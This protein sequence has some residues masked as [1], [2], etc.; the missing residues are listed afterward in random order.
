MG[1]SLMAQFLKGVP[2]IEGSPMSDALN[3]YM[4][5][6]NIEKEESNM[7]VDNKVVDGALTADSLIDNAD[8]RKKLIGR[9]D[10]L[11]KVK[12][13]FLI[14][15]TELVTMRQV[16]E[17]Y[18]VDPQ[19]IQRC[20]IRNKKELE[21][22][23]VSIIKKSDFL[24]VHH[25]HE[26]RSLGK[27]GIVIDLGNGMSTLIP[28]S[29]TT[30]LSPRAVLRIGMLLRDSLV[31]QEI[32]SQL[33]NVFEKATVEQK[34]EDLT[35][36]QKLMQKVMGGLVTNDMT[37]VLRSFTE[38]SDF[39]DR[40]KRKIE[41]LTEKNSELAS[42][43]ANL[44]SSNSDLE[45]ANNTLSREALTTDPRKLV[46]RIIRSYANLKQWGDY[47]KAW[48]EF[49]QRLN[50]QAGIN[51]KTRK[52][53]KRNWMDVIQDDEWPDCIRVASAMCNSSGLDVGRI[54]RETNAEV[55]SHLISFNSNEQ[56]RRVTA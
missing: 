25:V 7:Q 55:Y 49:Y 41:E 2:T 39:N 45:L 10:V 54:V 46:C 50:Y 3:S 40:H 9:T 20:C 23:G 32:R 44:E 51:V 24:R 42:S 22:D 27:A 26:E 16:S 38:L 19:V 17:Y 48:A 43:N 8:L 29:A 30:Y 18:E 12:Q 37:A 52:G 13:I 56:L 4:A 14:P 6:M 28:N 34:I 33:L 1:N 15:G 31:A 21:P 36:E 35:I 5:V 11:A 53:Y 47:S